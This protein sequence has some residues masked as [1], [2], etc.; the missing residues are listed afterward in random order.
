MKL[1]AFDAKL[2]SQEEEDE[3]ESEPL[4]F[5]YLDEIKREKYDVLF[6]DSC[7][8]DRNIDYSLKEMVK[9]IKDGVVVTSWE[10]LFWSLNRERISEFL[11]ISKEIFLKPLDKEETRLLLNEV[12]NFL[13]ASKLKLP[14]EVAETI[15]EFSQ[16]IP[17][18]A[19]KLFLKSFN[20]AFLQRK[21]G[22]DVE[23]VNKAA[24]AM[25]LHGLAEKLASLSEHQ[26]VVLKHILLSNDPRGISPTELVEIL[27]KD[28]ATISYHLNL[29]MSENLVFKQRIGRY[30]FYQV[31]EELKPIIQLKISTEGDF[32]A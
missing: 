32:L 20:E 5:K 11:P 28:K 2:F 24:K 29:L 16:G 12:A 25:S 31:E 10:P 18:L 14:V 1:R 23:A 8:G 13:S 30:S 22:V 6:I 17:G 26:I 15:C 9:A 3:S 21:E 27:H 4:L 19:I 7:E